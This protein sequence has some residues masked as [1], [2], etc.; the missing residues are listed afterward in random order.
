MTQQE[1]LEIIKNEQLKRYNWFDEHPLME[2]EVGIRVEEDR[3]L[4]YGT[5]ERAS[6]VTGSIM[7]FDNESKAL[8]N[9][10]KRV[11]TEKILF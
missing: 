11:R 9:F 6:L 1:A 10:I 7:I 8:D 5:D 4:V 2:N 3:W